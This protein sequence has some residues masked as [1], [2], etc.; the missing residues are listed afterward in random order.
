M[1]ALVDPLQGYGPQRTDLDGNVAMIA[2][3][4]TEL[5]D[6]IVTGNHPRLKLPKQSIGDGQQ[7]SAQ[8]QTPTLSSAPAVNGTSSNHLTPATQP[9]NLQYTHPS[10]PKSLLQAPRSSGIDPIFLTKS[11]V[12]VRAESHQKRQRIERTLEEQVQQKKMTARQKTSDQEALPDFDVTE[13]LRK[14][15]ELV[16]PYIRQEHTPAN[17]AA[18]SSDSFDDN[19][20]YSSQM[21]ESTSAATDE[22]DASRASRPKKIC[23]SF[24]EGKLCP[25]GDRCTFSHDPTTRQ[26]RERDES[27]AMDLDSSHADEQTTQ[28]QGDPPPQAL[29]REPPTRAA[30]PPVKDRPT[31]DAPLSHADQIAQLEAQL[32]ALREGHGVSLD[33]IPQANARENHESQEESAYSP[34]GPDEFGRDAILRDYDEPRTKEGARHPAPPRMPLPASEYTTRNEIPPSPLS[35]NVRVV[36]NHITSP[37]AP[38]PARVSPLAVSKLPQISQ[39]QREHFEPRRPS[40]TSNAEVLS[41]GQSPRFISQPVV[42]KKRRRGNES[43]DNLRN[44]APRRN[45][46]SPEIRVKDEPVSPPP[47]TNSTDIRQVRSIQD[48]PRQ[49]PRPSNIDNARPEYYPQDRVVYQTRNQVYEPEETIPLTPT[50]RRVISQN[51][52]H[53]IAHGEPDLR[54]IVS[55]RQ[56]R[57]PMSPVPYPVQYSD[58]QPRQVRAPSQLQYVSPTGQGPISQHRASVQPQPPGYAVQDRSPSPPPRQIQLPPGR[59]KVVPMAPPSGRIVVD[60]YGN[61]FREEILPPERSTSIAPVARRSEVDPRYEVIPTNRTN[62]RQSQPVP[63]DDEPHYIRRPPSP[64]SPQ[65]AQYPPTPRARQIIMSDGRIY[66]GDP[67]PIHEE[68]PRTTYVEPQPTPRFEESAGPRQGMTRV[69]SVRPAS[70]QYEMAREPIG[71]VQSRV[72]SGRPQPRIVSLGERQEMVP[73]VSRQVSIR[74]DDELARPVAYEQEERPRYQYAPSGPPGRFVEEIAEDGFY[75]APRRQ[76]VQRMG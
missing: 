36:R 40:Q 76:V 34:P 15:H 59:R 71:R 1:A 74:P 14:A 31:R 49:S 19:T 2:A 9:N 39:V 6:D 75:E 60:Q 64:T 27:Q 55:E 26:R 48:L 65:Y 20:F 43:G 70:S 4:L 23:K 21:N 3:Q 12:L 16:K 58:P 53:Y 46:V 33:A 24:E 42:T 52:Q 7:S 67:Y 35:N 41:A 54:R 28:G 63:V 51:G 38:Q 25:K 45:V 47:F 61:T 11:D 18:S 17:R 57:A 62:L 22:V 50:T 66:Q 73:Q 32:R 30:L 69:Q 72:Q 56:V 13:V 29:F 44:V 8:Q 68:G 10:I 5:R 37:F